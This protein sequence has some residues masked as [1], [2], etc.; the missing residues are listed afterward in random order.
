MHAVGELFVETL[1][2]LVTPRR[3]VPIVLVSIPLLLAQTRLSNGP[4]ALG[5]G[6]GMCLVFF[7][8]GPFLWRWL[9][10]PKPDRSALRAAAGITAYAFTS[11]GLVAAVAMGAAQLFE[12]RRTFL[13]G[14]ESLWVVMA[15]SA[16]GGWGL[17][18]DIET[19]QRLRHSRAHAARMQAELERAQAMAIRSHLDPHFLFNSLNAIAEWCRQDGAVAE[20]AILQLS[21]VLRGVLDGIKHPWWPLARELELVRGVVEIYRIRDSDS[22]S[23]NAAV[24]PEAAQTPVPPLILLPLIEN[25]MKYGVA[26]GHPGRVVL[27]ATRDGSECAITLCNPGPFRGPRAGGEGH[28]LVRTRLQLAY[29][30]AAELRIDGPDHATTA[31]LHF[32]VPQ[33][34]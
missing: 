8:T 18:R 24:S 34:V 13:T 30:A 2:G 3:F 11:V 7:T 22:V 20:A 26:A 10:V 15:M 12:V 23:L 4:G 25:A 6:V 21:D 33:S 17:G 27:T 28:K 1:R 19:E 9:G 16:V 32:T 14:P 5:L 31:H 29:G